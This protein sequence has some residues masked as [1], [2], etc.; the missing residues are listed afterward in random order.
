MPRLRSPFLGLFLRF[1]RWKG[2][3][4][5]V[6]LKPGQ[7]RMTKVG[8]FRTGPSGLARINFWRRRGITSLPQY[9]KKT[10]RLEQRQG[11]GVKNP[12]GLVLFFL[13]EDILADLFSALN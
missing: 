13:V 10:D 9:P 1:P 3:S 11:G 8:Q 5:E 12:S 4:A 6:I 7:V 2:Q